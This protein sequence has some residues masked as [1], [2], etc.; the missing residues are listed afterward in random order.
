[1]LNQITLK[2]KIQQE[3]DTTMILHIFI[4]KISFHISKPFSFFCLVFQGL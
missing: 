3:Q 4:E 2:N 1:M